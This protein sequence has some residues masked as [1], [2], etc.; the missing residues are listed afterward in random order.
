PLR[1]IYRRAISRSEVLTNPTLGLALPAARERR[2]RIARPAEARALLEALPKR[3][4]ALWATA[5]YAGLRRGELQ[6][7]RWQDVDFGE[8]V[9]R[10]ERGWDERVGPVAPKSR[11]G[12]RRVPLS[13]PLRSYLAAHRLLSRREADELV[14]G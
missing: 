2:G 1:A 4:R 11:A 3:D 8:G 13:K 14:F 7:L 12:R 9:I 10:V 5:L 6:A